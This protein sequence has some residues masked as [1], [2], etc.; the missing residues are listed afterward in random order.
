MSFTEAM[1]AER[2]AGMADYDEDTED[3][4][5]R[6]VCEL[7]KL[8]ECKNLPTDEDATRIRDLKTK[9]LHSAALDGVETKR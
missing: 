2:E 7:A 8:I 5:I 4:L 6:L 3:L 9:L 1:I